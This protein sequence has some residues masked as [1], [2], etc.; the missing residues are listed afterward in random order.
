MFETAARREGVA[1]WEGREG[2]LGKVSGRP[3]RQRY[4]G[5]YDAGLR[6]GC[7]VWLCPD[8]GEVAST[9]S[10][11]AAGGAGGGAGGKGGEG[12]EEKCH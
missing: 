5:E 4:A 11:E 12:V 7:G 6:D 8:E 10:E 9:R 3:R 1:G 2:V